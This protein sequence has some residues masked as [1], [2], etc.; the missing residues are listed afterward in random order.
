MPD[1]FKGVYN[2]AAGK[3]YRDRVHYWES[4][5]GDP[6]ADTICGS[7]SALRSTVKRTD[8]PTTCEACRT[9]VEEA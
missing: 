9:M 8:E 5:N 6:V 1:V 2:P 4:P 7:V 3:P